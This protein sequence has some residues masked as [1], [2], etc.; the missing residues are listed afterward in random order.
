MTQENQPLSI[1]TI[2]DSPHDFPGD[3]VISKWD[4]WPNGETIKDLNFVFLNKDVEI[5]RDLLRKKALHCL[6]RD[7]MDDPKILESWI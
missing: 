3:F 4:T 1:Y 6:G 7:P 2:Y 5:C